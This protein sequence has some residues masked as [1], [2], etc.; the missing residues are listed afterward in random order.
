MIHHASKSSPGIPSNG[1]GSLSLIGFTLALRFLLPE[2]PGG[3]PGG[4]GGG[5]PG[6]PG[7][8]GGGGPGEP[9]G[10]GPGGPGGGGP[11]APGGVS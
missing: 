6:G 9:G 5:G 7:G 11:G 1:Y 4:P 8:P 2:G 10:G 3:G